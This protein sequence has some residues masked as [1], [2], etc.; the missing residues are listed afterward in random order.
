MEVLESILPLLAG[1]GMFLYGMNLMASSI[2]K[3]AGAKLENTME[4]LTENRWA[5]LAL[6][7]GVTA[8]IQSSAATSITMI[9]FVNAGI[10][11]LV[12]TIPVIWG[13]NIGSTATS[14]ILRLGDLNSGGSFL[15]M[16]KPSAF[17]PVI[18]IIGAF[19]MLLAKKRKM[20][21]IS[22][23]LIGFGILF[24]GMTTMEDTFAPLKDSARF[25]ELFVSFKNPLIGILVG[26][27]LTAVIQSSS[28]SVGILQALSATGSITVATALPILLGQNIG[29]CVPV[30]LASIGNN[31]DAKRTSLCYVLFNVFSLAVFG[32]GVFGLNAIFHFERMGSVVNRGDIANMH[33]GINLIAALLLMPFVNSVDRLLHR[34]IRDGEEVREK[35]TL[36]CLDDAFLKN[37]QVAMGQCRKVLFDM[38]SV[39]RENAA[40][41]TGLVLNGYSE[42]PLAE[43]KAGE[44]FLDKSEAG[45]NAYMVNVTYHTMTEEDSHLATEILQSVSDF[46]RIGDYCIN[47]SETAEY[48]YEN[49]STFTP[50]AQ[51][52]LEVLF[53]AIRNVI[54][55][56]VDAYQSDD[57]DKI[58]FV[59]P[60]EEVVDDIVDRMKRNHIKR[61]RGGTCT[62]DNGISFTEILTNTERISDHCS[63]I[64]IYLMQKLTVHEAFDRKKYQ[65]ELHEGRDPRYRQYIEMYKREYLDRIE[66]V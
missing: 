46:E 33:T 59:E 7:T 57:L 38:C 23:L 48:M 5:G 19:I 32:I 28:A 14:Q 61:L 40:I 39:V 41:V 42:K 52:E 36:D 35:R 13:A 66:I 43:L 2:E 8:V 24:W 17:A 64:A 53:E 55:L 30:V 18:I 15:S 60:M 4:R 31:K 34:L 62:A 63:N 29:K 58:A 21:N 54:D 51:K 25:Q 45:I 65:D 3:L 10:M 16:L 44:D 9:G 27:L 11:A 56:T 37:P 6:G 22:N 20:K 49:K 47:L 50:D 26:F 12:Q 1:I